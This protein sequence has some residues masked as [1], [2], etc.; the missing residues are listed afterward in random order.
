M[1]EPTG[2][3]NP[4]TH[5]GPLGYYQE[6]DEDGNAYV[7]VQGDAR[8]DTFYQEQLKV[9]YQILEEL[10]KLNGYMAMGFNIQL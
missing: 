5:K 10:E 6:V 2:A 8:N 9:S 7:N 1:T 4:V 3:H